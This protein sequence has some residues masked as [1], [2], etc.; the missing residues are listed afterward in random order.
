MH[1]LSISFTHY[2]TASYVG[3]NGSPVLLLLLFQ[4]EMCG[5]PTLSL[6]SITP[7]QFLT[8][9]GAGRSGRCVVPCAGL[10]FLRFDLFPLKRAWSFNKKSFI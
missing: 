4:S 9:H 3:N 1:L 7:I 2:E 6:L 5:H 10:N 8:G